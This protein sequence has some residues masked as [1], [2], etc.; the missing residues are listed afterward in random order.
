MIKI[1]IAGRPNTGKSTLFNALTRSRDALVHDRP[2]VT[3]DVISGTIDELAI[4]FDT[5]GLEIKTDEIGKLGTDKALKAIHDADAV[6]F[7]VDGKSGLHPKDSDWARIVKKSGKQV[8]LLMNKADCKKSAPNIAEFYKLGFGDPIPVSAE[9]KIGLDKIYDFIENLRSARNLSHVTNNP[10]DKIRIAIMGQPNVGKS[11]LVNK[12]LGE[13]RVIVRDEPGV[14]RDTIQIETKF[15]GRDI[16]LIDTAGLRR[17]AGIKDELETLAALKSIDTIGKSD[18]VILIVDSTRDIENQALGIAGRIYDA[19]RILAVALNKWDLVPD[20]QRDE[21]LLKLKR[22]FANSFHQI[23][24]PLILPISAENG[25]GVRN[26]MKRVYGLWDLSRSHAATSFVNRT[27]EKLIEARQPP[28]SR[29]KR[30][31]KIKFAAQTGRNPMRITINVG[32]ASDI[33]ESYTRYLRKGIAKALS[34]E[35]LPV[36]VEYKK[37]E[38]PYD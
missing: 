25:S 16:T 11:T 13:A 8:L 36:I 24:K 23:V 27:I 10:P 12:I 34:W 20:A 22:Q 35:Q 17:K 21:K 30:P 32:G 14:T 28:M 18:A 4:L 38:N 9:H 33:P 19:G 3:R 29:L 6:L 1:A 15:L 2:G 37:T 7:I 31:M 26:L 5:A